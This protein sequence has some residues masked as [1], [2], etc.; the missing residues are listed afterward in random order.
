[1]DP[2][3]IR[4]YVDVVIG[5]N[6]YGLHCRVEPEGSHSNPVPMDMDNAA[7]KEMEM[8]MRKIQKK[9]IILEI[10]YNQ[11]LVK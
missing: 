8:A 6:V 10:M 2:E 7:T 3:L 1:M 11:T 4:D 9:M 5:E